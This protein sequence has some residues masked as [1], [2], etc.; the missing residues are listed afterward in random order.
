MRRRCR[1]KTRGWKV[2]AQIENTRGLKAN[3]YEPFIF[4][5]EGKDFTRSEQ[6]KI[7]Y[8]IMMKNRNNPS[9]ESVDYYLDNTLE[10]LAK[11]IK[12]GDIGIVHESK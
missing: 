2:I 7:I 3:I 10:Y 9:E 4:A 6:R 1:I 12:T 11:K 5:L 8:Q